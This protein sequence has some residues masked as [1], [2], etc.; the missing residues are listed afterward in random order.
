MLVHIFTCSTL[1]RPPNPH[2]VGI[3]MF[4][5]QQ[6]NGGVLRQNDYPGSHSHNVVDLVF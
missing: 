6:R 1:F 4:A 3:I 5:L 2:Q